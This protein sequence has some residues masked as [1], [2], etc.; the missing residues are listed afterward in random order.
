MVSFSVDL[1][2]KWKYHTSSGFGTCIFGSMMVF[3]L[4]EK[5]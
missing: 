2:A 3:L 5:S 1:T 4:I